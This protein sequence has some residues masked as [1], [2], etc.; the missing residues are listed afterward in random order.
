MKNFYVIQDYT[1]ISIWDQLM[2]LLPQLPTRPMKSEHPGLVD[3]PDGQWTLAR[4][5][6]QHATVG[7]Y[8]KAG[9]IEPEFDQLPAV[10]C[11]YPSGLVEK[12]FNVNETQALEFIRERIEK[13]SPLPK[14]VWDE[15]AAACLAEVRQN[16]CSEYRRKI[17]E[18]VEFKPGDSSAS[19]YK[20]NHLGGLGYALGILWNV[21]VI[22]LDEL[23][24]LER[25][26]AEVK[27]TI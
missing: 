2:A 10:F 23:Q 20:R 7:A 15:N 25:E 22:S 6:H 1:Q 24:K 19:E 18:I 8:Q 4:G 12:K 3:L 21:D 9:I 26:I 5:D 11:V 17:K 16:I 13:P 14:P 27:S